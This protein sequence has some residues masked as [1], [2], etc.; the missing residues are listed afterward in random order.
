MDSSTGGN[1]WEAVHARR[2]NTIGNLTLVGA[3]YNRSVKNAPFGTKKPELEK[4]I[5]SLNQYFRNV[6]T[7]GEKEIQDRSEE[8]VKTVISCFP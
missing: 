6:D 5:V 1:D 3:T 7:W 4:S 8:L 2:C